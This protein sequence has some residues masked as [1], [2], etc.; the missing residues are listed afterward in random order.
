MRQQAGRLQAAAQRTRGSP[1]Q[2]GSGVR[3]AAAVGARPEAACGVRGG[4]LR[5]GLR[6]LLA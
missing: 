6:E 2:S 3:R 4:G 1:E 5:L